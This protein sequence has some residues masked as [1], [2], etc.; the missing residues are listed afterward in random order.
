MWNALI[1]AMAVMLCCVSCTSRDVLRYD[2]MTEEQ[3]SQAMHLMQLQQLATHYAA[4]HEDTYPPSIGHL[5]LSEYSDIDFV[6]NPSIWPPIE[7]EGLRDWPSK[8]QIDWLNR[9]SDYIYLLSGVSVDRTEKDI[10]DLDADYISFIKVPNAKGREWVILGFMDQH[11]QVWS[12]SKAD[13]HI[14]Q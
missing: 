13:R 2:D 10:L 8:R 4:D 6:R 14:R 12:Y 7:P 11:Y 1:L 9:R 5:A 3:V